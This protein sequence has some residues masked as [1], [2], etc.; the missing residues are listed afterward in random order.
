MATVFQ[1]ISK[2]KLLK[3]I[4]AVYCFIAN[5]NSEQKESSVPCFLSKL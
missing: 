1:P 2:S 5:K 3:N 4:G